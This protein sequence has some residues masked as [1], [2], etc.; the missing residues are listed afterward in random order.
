M[1][2]MWLNR[3]QTITSKEC[4][5][6]KTE[7]RTSGVFQIPESAYRRS[8]V[9]KTCASVQVIVGSVP[10]HRYKDLEISQGLQQIYGVCRYWEITGL[11]QLP[12]SSPLPPVQSSLPPLSNLIWTFSSPPP[13]SQLSFPTPFVAQE[14]HSPIS[15][16][17][18]HLQNVIVLFCFLCCN[19]GRWNFFCFMGLG[20]YL[21]M[22]KLVL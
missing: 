5:T 3:M 13:I 7:I 12:S 2:A 4:Q 21:T 17:E 22:L 14:Y 11:I 9:S 1:L 15:Q 16:S 6:P 8:N 18:V 20:S 10:N 19:Q